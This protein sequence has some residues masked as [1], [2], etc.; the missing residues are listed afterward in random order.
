MRQLLGAISP[1]DAFI[2]GVSDNVMPDSLIDRIAW[3]SDIVA[4]ETK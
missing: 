4:K 3:I 2:L 1:E